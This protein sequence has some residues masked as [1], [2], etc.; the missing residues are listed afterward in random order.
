MLRFSIKCFCVLQK[1][2]NI[3]QNFS[4]LNKQQQQRQNKRKQQQV[5]TQKEHISLKGLS[6]KRR[7]IA[8]DT[9]AHLRTHLGMSEM[10]GRRKKRERLRETE[11]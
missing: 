6:N 3:K 4:V 11:R 1:I 5:E 9:Q 10:V 8:G 7:K 2:G